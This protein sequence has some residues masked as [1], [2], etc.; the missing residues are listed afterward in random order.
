MSR[1]IS[2]VIALAVASASISESGVE[3]VRVALTGSKRKRGSSTNV[4]AILQEL[5]NKTIKE[6]DTVKASKKVKWT[7][8]ANEKS[9]I[10]VNEEKLDDKKN[11]S[12]IEI[13]VTKGLGTGIVKSF[14]KDSKTFYVIFDEG[15]RTKKGQDA[16]SCLDDED[17]VN[18]IKE[19]NG[20][21]NEKGLPL[22]EDQL[23][24]V[25]TKPG[26]LEKIKNCKFSKKLK[27]TIAEKADEES[28]GTFKQTAWKTAKTGAQVAAGVIGFGLR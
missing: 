14:D 6:G 16:L 27:E 22:K 9:F 23:L 20:V 12:L 25:V 3:A 7:Y 2:T 17:F 24:K 26:K 5:E 11:D 8:D 1:I 19:M 18:I 13:N 4:K 21:Q 28:S 15:F 10:P